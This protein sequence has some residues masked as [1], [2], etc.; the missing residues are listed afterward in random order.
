MRLVDIDQINIP[1]KT[2]VMKFLEK[3]Y[4]EHP[5]REIKISETD[6]YEVYLKRKEGK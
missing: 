6:D 2:M 1:G 4:T 5:L 3:W